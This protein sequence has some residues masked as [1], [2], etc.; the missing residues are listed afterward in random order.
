MRAAGGAQGHDPAR[1]DSRRDGCREWRIRD[2]GRAVEA[3]FDIT[4]A[5]TGLLQ[6]IKSLDL[7]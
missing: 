4:Y 7:S 1:P 5:D 6:L 3:R 2:L